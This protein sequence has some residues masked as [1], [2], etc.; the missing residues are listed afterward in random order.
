MRD[1]RRQ[2]RETKERPKRANTVRSCVQHSVS[3]EGTNYC[4]RCKRNLS[5]PE[6]K[7]NRFC[8]RCNCKIVKGQCPKCKERYW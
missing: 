4:P 2:E 5:L 6:I 8:P 7:V 1:D 3:L